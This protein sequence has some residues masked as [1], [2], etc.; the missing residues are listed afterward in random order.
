MP[1][2][3]YKC[4]KCGS[5]FEKFQSITESPIKICK[6]CQGEV[7]RLI[8]KNGN[9]ILKG[10]GFYSTD[11]RKDNFSSEKQNSTNLKKEKVEKKD[12]SQSSKSEHKKD[13]Q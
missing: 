5:K 3:E 11:F 13:D 6:I 10:S 7:Y 1:T 9:F 12:F 4:K 2:Y 8:S